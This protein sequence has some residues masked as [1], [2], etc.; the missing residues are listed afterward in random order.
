MLQATPAKKKI[1]NPQRITDLQSFPK[2]QQNFCKIF[3]FQKKISCIFLFNLY[4]R[5]FE[6]YLKLIRTRSDFLDKRR[7]PVL[8]ICILQC[9]NFQVL[10]RNYLYAYSLLFFLSLLLL[11]LSLSFLLS[12]NSLFRA[13]VCTITSFCNR[14]RIPYR[15]EQEVSVDL[16]YRYSLIR[17]RSR[18]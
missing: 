6:V 1:K 3:Q 9:V 16:A 10:F 8:Y 11:S 12:I 13:V 15:W 17:F 4:T 5:V 7:F 2:A 18:S 14:T